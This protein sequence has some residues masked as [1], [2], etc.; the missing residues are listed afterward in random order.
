VYIENM[1]D[2]AEIESMRYEA[3]IESLTKPERDTREALDEFTNILGKKNLKSH[4]VRL[5]EMAIKYLEESKQY[6]EG[7]HLKCSVDLVKK[8]I[9]PDQET[10]NYSPSE[11]VMVFERIISN[12][13]AHEQI[14][15]Q[16][17]GRLLSTNQ[18][19]DKT[20]NFVEE[21]IFAEDV[22]DNQEEFINATRELAFRS[23]VDNLGS[24]VEQGSPPEKLR[25]LFLE[26]FTTNQ[27]REPEMWKL[28]RTLADRLRD[29]AREIFAIS[30]LE[31]ADAQIRQ[32]ASEKI[33]T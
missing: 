32:L 8:Q 3:L 30:R 33:A 31:G 26:K 21:T 23:V 15:R 27:L 28:F 12:P 9:E 11:T 29:Y 14:R 1:M 22:D 10:E 7:S 20:I 24:V 17:L 2:Q 16:L 6:Q 5:V 18:F 13:N 19:T 4:Q 25:K